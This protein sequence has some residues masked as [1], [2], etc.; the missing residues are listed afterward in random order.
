MV[1]TINI[2]C[3]DA[4][5]S[6]YYLGGTYNSNNLVLTGILGQ[7]LPPSVGYD[8]FIARFQ[9]NGGADYKSLQFFKDSLS[10]A[11]N[12]SII[13]YPNPS[14]GNIKIASIKNEQIT[15]ISIS[16]L[17]GRQIYSKI[18]EVSNDEV[19]INL[20]FL[21]QGNYFVTVSTLNNKYI[22][23]LVIVK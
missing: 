7:T 2:L 15:G 6:V 11:E 9:D 22:E 5:N 12:S 18:D 14:N 20:S 3:Y 4:L 13:V 16:D 21:Q 8:A 23:K 1:Q 10:K 17:L 19:E